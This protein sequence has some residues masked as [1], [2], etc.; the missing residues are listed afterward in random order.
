VVS[1]D[2]PADGLDLDRVQQSVNRLLG[3]GVVIREAAVAAP[4]FDAR[5]SAKSRV[6]RYMVLNRPVPDPF[7]GHTSWHVSAP[8]DLHVLRLA[9]DPLIGSHDFS[10]FCRA[11]K[12]AEGEESPSLVR[13]VIDA[14]WDGPEDGVLRFQIEANAFCH[15]M[16]RSIV[17]TLVEAGSG[18]RT[19]A[20]VMTAIGARDRR[21]AGQLAPPHG[22][23][24]WEVR[25]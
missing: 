12:V 9:C 16:V 13:R 6:Y 10:S 22:L 2:A 5:F 15:Q 7:L 14:R 21:A 1:F 11:K 3:G 23:C 17:G 18:R 4:D 8:L 19:A 24:L 20:D 25:Y